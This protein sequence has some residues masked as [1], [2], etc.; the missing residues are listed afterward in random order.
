ML[1]FM[2]EEIKVAAGANV[3]VLR[4]KSTPFGPQL[5]EQFQ[6]VFALVARAGIKLEQIDHIWTGSNRDKGEMVICIRTKGEYN[7]P[8][9]SKGLGATGTAEKIGKANVRQIPTNPEFNNA[10]AYIDGKTLLIG[11]YSTVSA[12][13]KNPKPGPVRFGLDALALPAAYYWVSGGD[14]GSGQRF[15]VKGVEALEWVVSGVPKARGMAMGLARAGSGA[16]GG[17]GMGGMGMGMRGAAPSGGHGGAAPGP[18]AGGHGGAPAPSSGDGAAS[19]PSGD[20]PPSDV[21]VAIGWNFPSEAGATQLETALNLALRA[22][23]EAI[24]AAAQAGQGMGQGPGGMG[25]GGEGAGPP[26]RGGHGAAGGGDGQRG[27]GRQA[28]PFEGFQQPG[29]GG[30]AAGGNPGPGA[31]G[32]HAGGAMPG[33]GMSYPGGASGGQKR[34][35]DIVRDKENVRMTRIVSSDEGGAVT[36]LISKAFQA[37]GASAINDGLFDGTLSMLAG[38]VQSWQTAKPDE[39][40]GTRRITDKPI[41]HGYSWMTELLPYVGQGS[42]YG[43][44]DFTKS[45]TDSVN[46]HLTFAVVPAFLNPSDPRS[47]WDGY[48]FQGLGLSHFAGMSGIEDGRNVV[49]AELPRSDPRAGIFGYDKI[50][51]AADITDG[52]SQTI[53]IVGTGEVV[54]PWVQGGGATIRG[55]RQPYFDKYTGLGSKG[56]PKAGTYVLFADGSARFI[57]ADISPE[58]F[59]AMCTMH[60]AEQIDMS[61]LVTQGQ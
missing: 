54:A 61:K 49:A 5:I 27:R 55:A 36:K 7:A 45:W 39:L 50:A 57:S 35:F 33:G 2:P 52:T 29:R 10:V 53:M 19:A 41:N 15:R 8:N 48:P 16:G 38:A 31:A 12:A 59:K 3:T 30:H 58:I 43:K 37:S 22:A 47:T 23:E 44:F 1:L 25:A 46:L 17:M 26:G 18:G 9:A 40:V 13:L 34:G 60:G 51:K 32:G 20:A 56:L 4:D 28:Q 21:E 42:L 24:A 11:R 14:D 6:P